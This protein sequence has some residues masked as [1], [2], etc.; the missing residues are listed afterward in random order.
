MDMDAFYASIEQRD[1]PGLRQRCVIVGG[2]PEERGVVS[3]AS[4]EARRFGVRSGMPMKQA[5]KLCPGA[6]LVPPDFEKYREESSRIMRILNDFTPLVEP[7]SLDEAFLDLKGTELLFGPPMECARKIKRRI[8]EEAGLTA[9]IGIGTS[10]TIAK[11]ASDF[12]KPDGL[13]Y[14]E[15]GK[16]REFLRPMDASRIPGVGKE[17][18][19]ILRGAGIKTIKDIAEAGRRRMERLLGG[20]GRELHDISMGVFSGK[21]KPA[22]Q[23]KTHTR[24][25]TFP[26]DVYSFEELEAWLLLFADQVCWELRK[27]GLRGKVAKL[28]VRTRDFRTIT[29]SRTLPYHINVPAPLFG[30]T[31]KMLEDLWPLEGVRLIGAGLGGLKSGRK[32][33]QLELFDAPYLEKQERLAEG[34]DR[35]REKWGKKA[36]LPGRL[37]ENDR[38]CR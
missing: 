3:A 31:R 17:G 9:S 32:A 11:I 19:R 7:L 14:V 15:P 37:L 34:I 10:K 30:E 2:R 6:V 28:K 35:I 29:R 4:Y 26:Q 8:L 1:H 13:V 18:E 25:H 12:G 38:E 36:I 22:R 23:A 33:L 5:L 27:R 16:E 21:V 24:E 20:F